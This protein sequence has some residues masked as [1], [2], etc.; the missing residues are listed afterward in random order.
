MCRCVSSGRMR[1]YASPTAES[2]LRRMIFLTSSRRSGRPR[3]G[4]GMPATASVSAC[5][6]CGAS[7]SSKADALPQ[8]ATASE[9]EVSS[10][11]DSLSRR[12]RDR[13]S[14]LEL[15]S[16]SEAVARCG[17]ASA[18]LLHEAPHK[19]Q[20]ETEAVAGMPDPDL[21]LPERLEDVRKIIRRN[22]D[23]AVGDAYNRILPLETQRH[24]DWRARWTVF[25]GVVEEIPEH[26]VQSDR[27]GDNH[28]RR[29][30]LR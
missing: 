4:S 9:E 3:S 26:L 14:N 12:R 13:E 29:V 30:G 6:L 17:N 21:G 18:L 25:L 22:P 1:L 5:R 7:W 23:S 10:R 15:T 8:R 28:H 24:M 16:S 2:G 11:L 19:R 27:V 20:A